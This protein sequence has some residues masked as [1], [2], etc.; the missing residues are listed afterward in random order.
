[1]HKPYVFIS[2]I[3][4][5][6]SLAEI[7]KRHISRDFIELIEVFVSSDKSS[8]PIGNNWLN[9]IDSAL[10][11]ARIELILCSEESVKRPWI[12]FEAGAGWVKGIRVVPVCHTG[13]RREDLPI[14]LKVLKAIEANNLDHLDELYNLLAEELGS[15]KPPGKFKQLVR[16]VEKFEKAHLRRRSVESGL[17]HLL[18]HVSLPVSNLQRSIDFYRRLLDFAP[19]P[20]APSR[21]ERPPHPSERPDFGFDGAWFV[22]PSNQHLHLVEHPG[23]TFRTSKVIDPR[24]CHFALRV[25][26]FNCAKARLREMERE[27]IPDP[28]GMGYQQLYFLDEDLHV[29]EI[30][31]G[32]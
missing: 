15:A 4:E 18:H 22:L 14:P 2:H 17:P 31:S 23:G 24:D 20:Q 12:N 19:L 32:F 6:A 1:V 26:D 10:K 28:L 9:D 3:H 8:I 25:R 13:L 27:F 29:V 11:A 30:N 7:L 5:D 16:D 21:L